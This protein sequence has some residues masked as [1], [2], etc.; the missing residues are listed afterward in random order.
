M[1]VFSVSWFRAHQSKILWFANTKLGRYIFRIHGYRSEVGKNK[2]IEILPNCITW[3]KHKEFVSE[4]RTYNKYA[5]RLYRAFKPIWWIF[6]FVDWLCLDRFI[7][8]Q[9][10]SFGFATLTVNPAAGAN[11]PV[12]GM[13]YRTAV[14]ETLATIRSGSG[15]GAR[16]S[17]TP[18]FLCGLRSSATSGQF[19]EL[20]RSILCFDTSSLSAKPYLN[21]SSVS[22]QPACSA[23]NTGHGGTPSV[24]CVAATP[25]ATNNLVSSD[26]S[27]LGVTSF[28][29]RTLA[30]I[31]V[32]FFINFELSAAGRAN[33]DIA[34]V[35]K[36]GFRLKW[37]LD[38]TFD[39]TWVADNTLTDFEFYSADSTSNDPRAVITYTSDVSFSEVATFTDS[40]SSV[41]AKAKQLLE[42][43]IF[44]DGLT[45]SNAVGR[46]FS[47]TILV[48][49][50]FVKVIGKSLS[51][52][53]TIFETFSKQV[54]TLYSKILVESVS[55]LD[56]FRKTISR[57]FAENVIVT[58]L[59]SLSFAVTLKGWVMGR[60]SDL[61]VISGKV[62]KLIGKDVDSGIVNGKS[63]QLVG[64]DVDTNIVIG[65]EFN[66]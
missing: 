50:S 28:A 40:V 30:S 52:T 64:K 8:L 36:F 35:S 16:V 21:I 46:I 25:A 61:G 63:I 43:T 41:S 15:N 48:A 17:N 47:E 14:D 23:K 6:H 19:K 62:S 34:G 31:S 58:A 45:M 42:S 54:T 29:N 32:N 18:E 4:F 51:Q 39:G 9:P 1:Q 56:A 11:S 27:Q 38:N 37:D 59:S 66:N 57:S 33:I 24:D 26:Y 20:T 3:R 5:K 60:I 10:L 44:L 12:D 49:D 53:V 7:W 22:V 13:A 2:I 65:K 55:L